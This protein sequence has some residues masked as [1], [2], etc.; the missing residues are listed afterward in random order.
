MAERAEGDLRGI[1]EFG[2]LDGVNDVDEH[3]I[4]DAGDEVADVL[5]AG[6]I[7][8]GAAIGLVSEFIGIVVADFLFPAL[9]ERAFA[10]RAAAL[11]GGVAGGWIGQGFG[12]GGG[13]GLDHSGSPANIVRG[14]GLI[15]CKAEFESQ[16]SKASL[17]HPEPVEAWPEISIGAH[18]YP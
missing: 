7:G 12:G 3:S 10:G 11:D 6:Q 16:V 17:G 1:E 15:I 13:I 8:H 5:V 9:L 2:A 4:S 18:R 14:V